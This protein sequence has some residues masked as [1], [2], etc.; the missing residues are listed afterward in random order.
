MTLDEVGELGVA[1]EY[2]DE[3]PDETV[4][5]SETMEAKAP[6]M[7]RVSTKR[8]LLI[9]CLLGIV[10]RLEG[11]KA[12]QRK[13]VSRVRRDELVAF[14]ARREEDE[15]DE[16]EAEQR[17]GRGATQVWMSRADDRAMSH[18]RPAHAMPAPAG[19]A[20]EPCPR[21]AGVAARRLDKGGTAHPWQSREL[22]LCC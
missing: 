17:R 9:L 2:G 22:T 7:A 21:T 18:L 5:W 4:W 15:N 3:A 11:G 13:C 20:M 1:Y 12:Q 19:P 8:L 16:E 6:G 10:R 14:V